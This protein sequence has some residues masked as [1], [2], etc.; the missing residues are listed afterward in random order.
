LTAAQRT[1]VATLLEQ[2]GP[3]LLA[4]IRRAYGRQVD[5][6]EILAETFCR[7]A[8][9]P[10]TLQACA[11][12]DLYLLTIA[13]N[14]CRDTWRREHP[15]Q[16]LLAAAEHDD[17]QPGPVEHGVRR[18]DAALLADAVA[19]LPEAQREV[20]VLRLSTNLTFEEIAALLGAPLGTVLSRMNAAL[21]RLRKEMG[22]THEC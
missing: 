21:K 13:R 20:V 9:R 19:M 3:R 17:G 22:C 15:T 5:A 2:H 6:E 1:F 11:R 14:L 4:Y 7:A 18:E 8:S 12:V 16:S 10:E